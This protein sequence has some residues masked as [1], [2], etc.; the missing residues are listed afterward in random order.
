MS[1]IRICTP[2]GA[3]PKT[4]KKARLHRLFPADAGL[5]GA[6]TAWS[7][8]PSPQRVSP[9][10]TQKKWWNK[11]LRLDRR[12]ANVIEMQTGLDA[13][14]DNIR[15]FFRGAASRPAGLPRYGAG[16]RSRPRPAKRRRLSCRLIEGKTCSMYHSR[17]EWSSAVRLAFISFFPVPA[18][19]LDPFSITFK[20]EG[21]E[22]HRLSPADAG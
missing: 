13:G 10:G 14:K 22:L 1:A 12:Y 11:F 8:P 7:A 2:S 3:F 21:H 4:S 17:Y 15:A 5:G 20:D 9:R 19:P 16:R 6:R 18:L